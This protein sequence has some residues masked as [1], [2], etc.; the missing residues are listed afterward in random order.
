MLSF[1]CV[2]CR[3]LAP[4]ILNSGSATT[5][6][7]VFSFGVVLWELM[8]WQLPWGSSNPWGIVSVVTSGGRLA[9]PEASE[10]PGPDSGSW[11]QLKRYIELME[12]CWAQEA[13]SRPSFE[14]IMTELTSIDPEAAETDA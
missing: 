3:W 9:I 6:S 5:A 2:S 11:P 13:K 10:L 8:T 12:R 1:F 4:E 14:E 7:D